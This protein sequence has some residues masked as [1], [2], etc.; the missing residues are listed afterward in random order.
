MST[1][2]TFT[3][4]RCG[5]PLEGEGALD[6]RGA[7]PDGR[8]SYMHPGCARAAAAE[9]S[10]GLTAEKYRALARLHAAAPGL[11]RELEETAAWLEERAAVLEQTLGLPAARRRESQKIE[12]A[13]IRGRAALLRAK[14]T[15]A[16]SDPHA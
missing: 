6:P 10:A 4:A 12:V 11:L 3:C 15:V 16:R 13:R 7:G 1:E 9:L 8:P 14:A 2:A 5:Q